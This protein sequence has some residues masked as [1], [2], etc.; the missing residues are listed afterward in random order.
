M[1]YACA[2]DNTC[3]HRGG[4]ECRGIAP[5]ICTHTSQAFTHEYIMSV[6]SSLGLM[7]ALQ[8]VWNLR[9]ICYVD[10]VSDIF[11][12]PLLLRVAFLSD[13]EHGS[14][15][16]QLPMLNLYYWTPEKDVLSIK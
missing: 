7:D 15:D 14:L 11:V 5:I 10:V 3:T 13:L 12:R 8:E 2:L 4:S 6:N 16:K 9:C 1:W